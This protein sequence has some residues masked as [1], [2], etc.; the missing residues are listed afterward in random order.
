MVQYQFVR[1]RN[2]QW[3]PLNLL[4]FLSK[5]YLSFIQHSKNILWWALEMYWY[6]IL[7]I[8]GKIIF[9][10]VDC[11]DVEFAV[12]ETR[13]P[14]ACAGD[15]ISWICEA[16]DECCIWPGIVATPP[17]V[18]TVVTTWRS[19]LWMPPAVGMDIA[20]PPFATELFSPVWGW[21]L[22]CRVAA[23]TESWVIR[24][25]FPFARELESK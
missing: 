16:A 5:H 9:H 18:S 14:G 7:L 22:P 25:T 11:I 1:G 10:S 19:K 8:Y 23:F 3:I 12:A 15:V 24:T 4:E 20:V 2:N 13:G 6:T 21:P 17:F